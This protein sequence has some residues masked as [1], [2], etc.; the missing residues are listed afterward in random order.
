VASEIRLIITH[1][2]NLKP[3]ILAAYQDA[4]PGGK[5]FIETVVHD[6]DPDLMAAIR[7]RIK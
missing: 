7:E 6:L 5:R 3:V 2:Q 4:S 1:E